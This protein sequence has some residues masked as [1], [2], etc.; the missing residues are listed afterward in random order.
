MSGLM[1]TNIITSVRLQVLKADGS[2]VTFNGVE[3]LNSL[4]MEMNRGPRFN[5]S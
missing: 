3:L 2:K 1:K 4:V 5:L